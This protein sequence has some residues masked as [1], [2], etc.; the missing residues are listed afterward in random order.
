LVVRQHY[1]KN[2]TVQLSSDKIWGNEPTKETKKD[3]PER[4]EGSLKY[5]RKCFTDRKEGSLV[6]DASAGRG[7]MKTEVDPLGFSRKVSL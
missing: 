6:M 7:E 3:R 1:C 2:K 5:R 4:N